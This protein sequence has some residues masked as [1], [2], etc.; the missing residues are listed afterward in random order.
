MSKKETEYPFN[1]VDKANEDISEYGYKLRI[2]IDEDGWYY[3]VEILTV[4]ENDQITDVYEFAENMF[5]S[6]LADCVNDAWANVKERVRMA[7]EEK[8]KQKRDKLLHETIA[9]LSADLFDYIYSPNN[10]IGSSETAAEIISLAEKFEN[11]LNWQ[12]PDNETRDYILEL[13]KFESKVLKERGYAMDLSRLTR[14]QESSRCRLEY[15]ILQFVKEHGD[16]LTDYDINEFGLGEREDEGTITKV[17]NFFDN[18]GCYFNEDDGFNSNTLEDID[19]ENWYDKLYEG[20]TH[21]AYQ[22]LYI[23]VDGNGYERLKY[24]RFTNGGCV[25]DGDQA[26]PDHDYVSKLSLV[27]LNYIIGAIRLI[28]EK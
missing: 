15:A 27:D 5:E 20:M 28:C 11:E 4:D 1:L 24:Y 6:E 21:T 14:L 12:G 13:D 2:L 16:D 25:F 19:D 18:G 7:E 9:I 3:N 26:E 22:C 23:V 10:G 8:E 17:W